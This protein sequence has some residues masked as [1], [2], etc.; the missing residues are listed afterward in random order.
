MEIA[1]LLYGGNVAWLAVPLPE[2]RTKKTNQNYD[3]VAL[4][5]HFHHPG[6]GADGCDGR[7]RRGHAGYPARPKTS[8]KRLG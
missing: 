2:I 1:G 6:A 5:S 4:F 8:R 7:A 3:M